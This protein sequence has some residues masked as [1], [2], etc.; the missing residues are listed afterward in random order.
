[1]L[2]KR[3]LIGLLVVANLVL[4][5]AL[6]V[7]SY[8]LPQALAQRAGFG[9]NYIAATAKASGQSFETL[10]LLDTTGHRLLAVY[11]SATHRG[12]WDYSP[13]RDLNADFGGP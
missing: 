7:S 11:Q 9:G 10:F 12:Q 4:V 3:S 6:V 1:M 8:Q 2:H 13:A 5:L